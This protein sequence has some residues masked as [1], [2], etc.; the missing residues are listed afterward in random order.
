METKVIR[1][2]MEVYEAIQRMAVPFEDSPDSV[3]RRI[4]L[5]NDPQTVSAVRSTEQVTQMTGTALKFLGEAFEV[6]NAI[7][8]LQTLC[9][10]LQR[11][12][13]DKR[14][15]LLTYRSRTVYF[16]RN[17]AD[18]DVGMQ[19]FQIGQSGI[20]AKGCLSKIQI[21]KAIVG[22]AKLYGYRRDQFSFTL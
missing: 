15:L 11:K 14:N 18:V 1:I 19:A 8:V 10:I 9:E 6:R 21:E 5:P 17:K 2:S 20:W 22:V 13:P 3:L 4:L 12:H 7:A 16:S